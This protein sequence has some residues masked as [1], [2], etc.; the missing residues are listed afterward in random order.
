MVKNHPLVQ[1]T[2]MGI[3]FKDT[4]IFGFQREINPVTF[5]WQMFFWWWMDRFRDGG[6][7]I[8]G[9]IAFFL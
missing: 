9:F 7:V 5:L 3:E 6:A 2:L 4:D 1:L 8:F